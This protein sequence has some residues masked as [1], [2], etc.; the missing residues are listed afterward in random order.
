MKLYNCGISGGKDS[1]ALAV[2]AAKESGIPIGELSFTAADTHNEDQVTYDH[3]AWLSDWLVKQGCR[4]IE[5]LQPE[6]GFFELAAHKKRFPSRRAQFCTID[7]KIKPLREWLKKKWAEGYEVTV[8]NGKRLDESAQRALLMKNQPERAFSDYWGC[9]EWMPLRHWK[10]EDVFAIHRRYGIPLNPLYDLGARRVGC[11]PCI[12]CGKHEIRMVAKHRPEKIAFIA[13]QERKLK[14]SFLQA[15]ATPNKFHDMHYTRKKDGKKL[16]AA[17][18]GQVVKWSK[19]TH[20]GEQY[21]LPMEEPKACFL[22][23]HACE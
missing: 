4:P 15:K 11:F 18:I 6:L 2:W 13:E 8:L 5:W 9:E 23:Y 12:N 21:A 1:T 16:T 14:S 17:S 22:G 7:L 19:T 20:G 3:I 10:L